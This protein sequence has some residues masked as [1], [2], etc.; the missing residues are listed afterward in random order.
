MKKSIQNFLRVFLL[1]IFVFS[2]EAV[3][4][5]GEQ[6]NLVIK[7]NGIE[8]DSLDIALPAEGVASVADSDGGLHEVDARSV[9]NILIE[10]DQDSSAFRI[11]SLIYYSSFSAFYLKCIDTSGA[12]ELCDDWQYNIDGD[13]PGEGMDQSILSGGEVVNIFFGDEEAEEDIPD[14]EVVEDTEEVSGSASSGSRSSKR[15]AVIDEVPIPEIEIQPEEQVVVAPDAEVKT[16]LVKK[17]V[18]QKKIVSVK[19]IPV[20]TTPVV[21]NTA[22]ALDAV[23]SAVEGGETP[24][25]G[26]FSRLFRWLFGF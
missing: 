19:K 6:V 25:V 13:S 2:C 14:E 15:V 11:S 18:P 20:V 21:E 26:W 8:V 10:G 5:E 4:A 23:D 12:D 17:E 16:D 1:T 9:L 24:E 22:T 7:N 3:Y